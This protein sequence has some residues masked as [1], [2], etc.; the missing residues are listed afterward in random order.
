MHAA[1]V[2]E[3][4][5]SEPVGCLTSNAACMHAQL[6][7]RCKEVVP[8]KAPSVEGLGSNAY[9]NSDWLVVDAGSVVAHVFEEDARQEYDIEELWAGSREV[10]SLEVA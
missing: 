3:M 6:K 4:P 10:E 5:F 8:G 1:L 9:E 7:E 2:V